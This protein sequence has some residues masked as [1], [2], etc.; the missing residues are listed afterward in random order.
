MATTKGDATES[1]AR[2]ARAMLRSVS[3]RVESRKNATV[4]L[5][6]SA[7]KLDALEQAI[8]AWDDEAHA[9]LVGAGS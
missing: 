4:T 7:E 3:S 9:A 1:A 8:A 2:A 5:K 6:V